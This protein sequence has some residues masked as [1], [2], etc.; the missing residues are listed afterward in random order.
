[1]AAALILMWGLCPARAFVLMGPPNPG[2]ASPPSGLNFNYTDDFGAPKNLRRFFRWNMPELTYSFDASFV[3]YFGLEGMD[4]VHDAFGVVNDFFENEDY[5]GMSQLDFVRHGFAGN[6]ATHWE[7]TT[8]K[9]AQVIDLKSL[10]L[11]MLLNQLGLGNPHR[12]AFTIIDANT[13]TTGSQVIFSTTLRNYDPVSL[14]ETNR[15]NGINYSYRLVHDAT[16]VTSGGSLGGLGIAD[17]EEFTLS[18]SDS[19]WS[20]VAG[21]TDAF[22]GNTAFYWT[23]TP[24]RYNFGVFYDGSN[25][26]GGRYEPRHALTY[27]DAGGLR[28]L[29]QTNTFAYEDLD[30]SV[31][32]VE[33]AQFLNT[34]DAVHFAAPSGRQLPI[35]PRGS[36]AG[37]ALPF[38]FPLTSRLRGMPINGFGG[39]TASNVVLV[40]HGLRGG[41]D[42]MK[43][44]HRP[45]DTIIGTLFNETNFVWTD[46]FISTNANN[47]G[48][49]NQVEPGASAYLLPS[50]FQYFTQKIGR[51]VTIPDILLLVDDLGLSPDGVPMAFDRTSTNGWSNNAALQPGYVAVASLTN[52]VGPGNIFLPP[53]SPII[54]SF[55]RFTENFEVIWSGEA[56]VMGNQDELPSLWGWIKGPGPNDVVVFP[57]DRTQWLVENSVIPDTAPPT[58]TMV[59]DDGGANPIEAQTL[60]RTGETLTLIGNELASATAIEIMNGNLVVQTI[61]PAQKYV[62]SNQRID[63]PAG[64]ISDAGEGAARTVR[65]WNS[66]GA[67]EVGPQKFAIET[68]LPVITGTDYDN[69]VLDRAQSITIQGYGFKSKGA[70][71]ARL[72]YFRIDDAAGAAVDDNG[73]GAGGASNGLPRAATFE[74]VSDTLAVL[75]INA[76]EASADGSN[77]RLRVARKTVTNADTVLSAATNPSFTAITTKPVV[78]TLTQ[79]ESDGTAWTAISAN[80]AFRRDRALEINGTA[81]NTASVIEIIQEDGT[82]FANP[83]FIQLPNAGVFVEDNGS[84]ILMSADT[85]PYSD[86]DSN[87]TVKR[88]FKVY[89]AVGNTDLNANQM[90]VVNTQPVFDAVGAFAVVG[91]MNRD[92]VAGDDINIFGSGLKAVA[93]VIFSDDNDTTASHVTI[94]LP[95]PGITVA[96]N[97]ITIDTQVYQVGGGADTDINSSRRIL[98]LVSARDNATLPLAQRFYVGAPPSFASLSGL[99]S[100]NYTRDNATLVV[101]GTGFGHMTKLEIVDANGNAIAGVPAIVSG[102]DGT[103][104][105]GLNISN[106]TIVSVDA[107]ATGWVTSVHLLDSVTD[108]SR[109]VKITTPFGTVTS[110]GNATGV[111]TVSAVPTLTSLPGTFAGGGYTADDLAD[112][113]DDNGT[114]DKSEGDLIINGTNF[115]GLVRIELMSNLGGI[116][117]QT[118]TVDPVNPPAGITFNAEGTQVVIDDAVINAS[119]IG[120]FNATVRVTSV[121]GK[122]VTSGAIQTQN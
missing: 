103:G 28:Y 100:G 109:R 15:I 7:N 115:R 82:S 97:Q 94:D 26:M 63:I 101:G 16:N 39:T 41:V 1:M 59:S 56:S 77:R 81:L 64:V 3:N 121:A 57:Q 45:F 48:G 50:T 105:L 108:A 62:I 34:R 10:T 40:T 38:E 46:T 9:N 117:D 4:A 67:S 96:D 85:I 87:T 88:A 13:N 91:Y 113:T 107:N 2:E 22:Y 66:V 119:W 65:V 106:A 79:Q 80:G 60:T 49:L 118:F 52:Q 120:E 69:A 93:Q 111:F 19:T 21:V 58:I 71:E 11:G 5:S 68:G 8:A 35:F 44:H 110:W 76:I 42:R 27:D 114:Y 31:T 102:A 18:T 83:V 6:Y 104:G 86:A 92:K 53:N 89:N 30:L 25:A 99:S 43:F 20:A 36:T 122:T 55:T 75:P 84:R 90:F 24:T 74:V 12:H 29:Y 37:G 33:P 98:K 72:G 23:D 78:N 47:V 54:W 61:M 73:T 51:T 70:G 17:M 32:L 95:A 112:N 14:D 116:A